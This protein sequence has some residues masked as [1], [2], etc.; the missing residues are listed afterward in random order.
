VGHNFITRGNPRLSEF[1][2]TCDQIWPEGPTHI[3]LAIKIETL[4][5]FTFNRGGL[6]SDLIFSATKLQA[7]PTPPSWGPWQREGLENYVSAWCVWSQ[8]PHSA[9]KVIC[10]Y[11][12]LL[13]P[14]SAEELSN[15]TEAQFG[16]W[17][18]LKVGA[19]YLIMP[20]PALK[21]QCPVLPF[22]GPGTLF[23][24]NDSAPAS[25]RLRFAIAAVMCKAVQPETARTIVSLLVKW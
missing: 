22:I 21:W 1:S 20:P 13:F 19:R 18:G 8:A 9:G 14:A 7:P 10:K 4:A 24:S 23:V 16:G 15:T 5:C 12:I 6:L 17:P 11:M 3:V 25:Y 2:T